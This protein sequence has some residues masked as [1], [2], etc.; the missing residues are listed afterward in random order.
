VPRLGRTVV[1]NAALAISAVHLLV[2]MERVTGRIAINEGHGWDGVDYSIML[3]GWEHGTVNT[4]LRPLIVQVNRPAYRLL[5]D[6]VRAF[7]A[8]NYVYI[9]V[10]CLAV[11]LLFDR[12]STDAAAKVLLVLNLF[13]SI[14]VV[15]YFAFYPVLIDA[16]AYAVLTLAIYFMVTGP[17]AAAAVAVVAAV[18]AREFGVATIVFGVVRD[19]RRR[20]PVWIVACT[21]A[22]AIVAFFTWRAHVMQRWSG[23]ARPWE[24]S[25]FIGN[26]EYWRDPFFAAL[27]VYFTLTVFGGISLFVIARCGVALRHCVREPE[28]A[29]YSALLLAAAAMGD[30]DLWR[31]LAYLLPAAAVL[32]A[33]CARQAALSRWHMIATAAIVCVATFVTQRPLQTVDLSAYFLDWF[34][35]YIRQGENVPLPTLPSL[36]PVWGWR[37]LMTAGL[38]W[39]LAV[40]APQPEV[41]RPA[42]S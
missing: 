23:N 33:V 34:P 6:P 12:Y 9:G 36:W 22:P 24:L 5:K 25:T 8:M 21:Y 15:K 7:R 13:V 32:F 14:A 11:C 4:A 16:G 3:N 31:Y 26:L 17:R 39:L 2:V 10:L 38:L 35:Y 28:W 41:A 29:V 30:A 1:V 18:M 20:V 42:D 37:F 19:L 27:F 40:L